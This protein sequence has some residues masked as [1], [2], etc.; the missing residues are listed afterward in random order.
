MPEIK[1]YSKVTEK[2]IQAK[3]LVLDYPIKPTENSEGVSSNFL[4]P[5]AVNRGSKSHM[6]RYELNFIK[7]IRA[8][9]RIRINRQN[10]G[11]SVLSRAE[12]GTSEHF[13]MQKHIY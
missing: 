6:Y 11:V 8:H 13:Y 10:G 1:S 4:S 2:K 5:K 3:D 7:P 9:N 12:G